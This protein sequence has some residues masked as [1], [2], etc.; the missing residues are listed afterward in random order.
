MLQQLDMAG[1]AAAMPES[2][3]TP[4]AHGCIDRGPSPDDWI[5]EQNWHA[6]TAEEHRVWEILFLRQKEMLRHRAVSGF[7]E[8]LDLLNFS[9][10]EIPEFAKLNTILNQRNGWTVV[11]VPGLVPDRIFFQ[12]LSERRFPAGNFIREASQLDY[13]EEP[14]VFHD[15]FGHVPLLADQAFA[16][17]MHALGV[18]GL[19]AGDNGAMHRLARLYWYIVEF[20][21][22]REAG[23]V[24]I[25]GA[26]I[27]SSFAE[28]RYA[29]ESDEPQRTRFDLM[30]VLRTRYRSD[31]FQRGYFVIESFE[32]L[33][34]DL[35]GTD[36]LALLA[37]IEDQPDLEPD[38]L[39]PGD[40]PA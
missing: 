29:L 38:R 37:E 30:R 3:T 9:Q 7:L 10:S 6:F 27:A 25:F 39:Y 14:D 34:K 20:G 36:L 22:V 24:R 8:G 12:L 33:L 32:E 15:V 11:A 28:S 17:F 5:I 13:L 19:Q 16:D 4:A 31:A 26:G 35:Q 21:L 40:R 2:R 18:L 23:K 1:A